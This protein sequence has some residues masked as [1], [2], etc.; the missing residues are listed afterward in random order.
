MQ[1]MMGKKQN[2]FC[3][4]LAEW[5]IQHS[6]M[7][8]AIT[9]S[10]YNPGREGRV[11]TLMGFV[12]QQMKGEAFRTRCISL[13]ITDMGSIFIVIL[14][15]LICKLDRNQRITWLLQMFFYSS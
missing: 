6:K 15:C 9:M 13:V 12:M 11:Q 5:K 8:T 7:E 10:R 4:M 1:N 14:W 2:I 3:F